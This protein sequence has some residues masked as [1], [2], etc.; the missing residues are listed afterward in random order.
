MMKKRRDRITDRVD[1]RDYFPMR[2]TPSEKESLKK[3]ARSK[4]LAER[5]LCVDYLSN[6]FGV[7][8]NRPFLLDIID[9]LIPDRSHYVRWQS[10]IMLEMIAKDHHHRTWPLI[11]K[12][13]SVKNRDIRMGVG[14]CILEHLLSDDFTTYFSKIN[15]TIEAGNRRFAYTFTFCRKMG[16]AEEPENSKLFDALQQELIRKYR[17]KS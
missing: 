6:G 17:R 5:R 9:E 8:R 15:S 16:Q 2:F 1:P 14:L 7:D 4:E 10:L 13:G 12:W 3:L 11:V